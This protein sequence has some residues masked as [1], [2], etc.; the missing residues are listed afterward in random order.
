MAASIRA[1]QTAE[2]LITPTASAGA[3]DVQVGPMTCAV[4]CKRSGAAVLTQADVHEQAS[5]KDSD[6]GQ[7]RWSALML[8]S[9]YGMPDLVKKLVDAGAKVEMT[10]EVKGREIVRMGTVVCVLATPF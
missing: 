4:Y 6:F 5:F 7:S 8:A 2:I 1:R 9:R 3:I 10:D